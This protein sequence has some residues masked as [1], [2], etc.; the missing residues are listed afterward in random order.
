MPVKTIK[1]IYTDIGGNTTVEYDNNSVLKFNVSEIVIA[2]TEPTTGT[3][4]YS[5][6]LSEFIN[7]L[8]TKSDVILYNLALAD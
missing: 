6:G 1:E 3:I 8:P 4:T 7:A 2:T 5:L